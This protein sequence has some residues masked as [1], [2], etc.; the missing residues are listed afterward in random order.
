[1]GLQV[2]T[3]TFSFT[4]EWLARR[5]TLEQL[6]TRV[7]EL[8]LGPGL[9]VIGYQTWR[10]YPALTAREIREFRNLV[11]RLGLAPAAL[12]AEV[13][14]LRRVDRPMTSAEAVEFLL[15]QLEVAAELG[16]SLLRVPPSVPAAV[17]EQIAP[18]AERAGV[19]VVVEIQGAEMPADDWFALALDFSISMSCVPGAFAEA[20]VRSGMQRD[21]V[22]ALVEAWDRG[23]STA[24]LFG[25]IAAIDAPE[26]ARAE[27]RSGFVRFGRQRPEAWLP[28]V[29][30]IAYA[31]AKFWD[32][33]ASVRTGQLIDVL[34]QGGY[35]G[36]VIA[37]WGGN[38]W[39]ELDDV[40]AFAVV[41]RHHQ[42]CLDLV[43][44]PA[45]EVP[46]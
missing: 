36:F 38:A 28:L 12:G 24:E 35:D 14:L 13:D 11:E 34:R 18:A 27:A 1:M 45:A 9:E 7:A 31:H 21:D 26:S 4:D 3:S 37:E 23:A 25:A 6:L 19:T 41:R 44:R 39:A 33:S 10:S 30:R 16:F 20:V 42:L 32:E 8:E 17:L 2:G 22:E 46:A 40:D 15:P 43:S 29:P 5:F